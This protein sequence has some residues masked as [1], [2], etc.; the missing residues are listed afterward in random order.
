MKPTATNIF[1]LV[2]SV[3]TARR[4]EQKL[5]FLA[6]L[7]LD[8]TVVFFFFVQSCSLR[9]PEILS[10]LAI[11][12][13]C[14]QMHLPHATFSHEQSL[15]ST[16]DMCAWLKFELRPK[17]GF[18]PRV[19][20]HF[21]PHS[22]EFVDLSDSRPVVHASIYPRKIHGRM[23]LP[24][25]STLPQVMS[26][27][28]SSSTGPCF[29][30]SNQRIDDHDGIE[31]IGVKPLSYSQSLIHS[32]IRQRALQR[33][34]TRTSKTNKYVRCWLHHCIPKYQ[35]N[36]MQKVYRSEKQMHNE[37]KACH[38]RRETLMTS[39]SRDLKVSG[40]PD[41]VL[42]CPSELGPNTFSERNQSNEPGNRFEN[43]CSFCF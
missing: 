23:A 11:D 12:W 26:P 6:N 22:V 9:L 5:A 20:F 31:E 24:R 2:N 14:R 10:S 25:N 33:H 17:R 29:N 32:T 30:L 34:W 15:H 35:G 42:S 36:L 18:H 39:S 7:I 16:D 41:A 4:L 1:V 43:K 28:G 21:A 8:R 13:G 40:K 19:M 37:H 27:K 38:S 3:G